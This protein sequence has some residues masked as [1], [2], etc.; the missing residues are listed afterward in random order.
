M[1][2]LAFFIS[3]MCRS[4]GYLTKVVYFSISNQNENAHTK[5]WRN[6]L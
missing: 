5:L 6:I 2:W 4:V 1:H 3:Y